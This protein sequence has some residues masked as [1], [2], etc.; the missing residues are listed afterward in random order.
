MQ[1][2]HEICCGEHMAHDNTTNKILIG[3]L[4]WPSMF[5]NVEEYVCGFD[6]C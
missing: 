1:E 4:W 6:V 3:G 2:A 5:H